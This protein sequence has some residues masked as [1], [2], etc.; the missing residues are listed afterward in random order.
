MTESLKYISDTVVYAVSVYGFLITEWNKP[1]P[2]KEFAELIGRHYETSTP[3]GQE[4][5]L[6]LNLCEGYGIVKNQNGERII[7]L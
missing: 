4:I 2:M 7:K 1:M 5:T 6:C 3:R